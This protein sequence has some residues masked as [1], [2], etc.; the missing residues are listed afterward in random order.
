MW[1]MHYR[2]DFVFL[3]FSNISFKNL[4]MFV[5]EAFMHEISEVVVL[6]WVQSETRQN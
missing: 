5:R 1:L 6:F 2:A 3:L 4:V